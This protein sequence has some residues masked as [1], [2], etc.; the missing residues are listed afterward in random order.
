MYN[1]WFAKW[2][3]SAVQFPGLDSPRTNEQDVMLGKAVESRKKVSHHAS[4]KISVL[5]KLYTFCVK[6][7]CTWFCWRA[8]GSRRSRIEQKKK[9]AFSQALEPKVGRRRTHAELY[10]LEHYEEQIKPL[11]D[12]KK[13]VGNIKTRGEA[14]VAARKLSQALFD[15]EEDEVKKNIQAMYD[16]QEPGTREQDISMEASDPVAIQE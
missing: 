8:N 15:A 2:P 9:T 1:A 13:E 6:Q 16:S 10:S 12:A 5:I 14:L 11:I 7:I 3:E 4:L